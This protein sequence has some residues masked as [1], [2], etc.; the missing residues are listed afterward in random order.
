[1]LVAVVTPVTAPR[2]MVRRNVALAPVAMIDRVQLV[3]IAT[4][5]E[6]V[7]SSHL[8][9]PFLRA[10]DVRRI[11]TESADI[12]VPQSGTDQEGADRDCSS[13]VEG[14]SCKAEPP[15]KI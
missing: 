4:A 10:G 8:F 9:G 1:M 3:E 2:V 6:P 15:L 7:Q 13:V 11:N 5:E 14:F 12:L